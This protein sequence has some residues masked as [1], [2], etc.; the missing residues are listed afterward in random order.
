MTIDELLNGSDLKPLLMRAR[1]QKVEKPKMAVS[2]TGWWL[3]YR[4]VAT[5]EPLSLSEANLRV[6]N[7]GS[8]LL[9]IA[10]QGHDYFYPDEDNYE[11]Y[12]KHA[13]VFFL[14]PAD[15]IVWDAINDWIR[16]GYVITSDGG[17]VLCS[18]F[19][20]SDLPVIELYS[21]KDDELYGDLVTHKLQ[22]LWEQG[23]LDEVVKAGLGIETPLHCAIVETP[24]VCASLHLP[25]TQEER[26]A[27][28]AHQANKY[29]LEGIA[30]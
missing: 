16:G 6:L 1:L 12:E 29:A 27:Y 28:A 14:N 11:I 19:S 17:S 30:S 2:W 13:M 9:C 10:L 3:Q 7:L 8:G 25:L 22:D 23:Q 26:D 4:W 20:N 18:P 24:R 5:G 21:F 15:P